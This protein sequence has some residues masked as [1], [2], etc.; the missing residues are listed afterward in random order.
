MDSSFL[1]LR[2]P[3]SAYTSGSSPTAVPKVAV[4]PL[5]VASVLDHYTRRQDSK[6]GVVGALLGAR[7]ED[8]TESIEVRNA[9]PLAYQEAVDGRVRLFGF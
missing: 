7:L 6:S 3:S 1:H 9:F 8:G 5:V 4:D 2:L